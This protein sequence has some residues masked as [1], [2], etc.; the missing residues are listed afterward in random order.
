MSEEKVLD[1]SVI[2]RKAELRFNEDG[3]H[4]L[5]FVSD[6]E[7]YAEFSVVIRPPMMVTLKIA[8]NVS[9]QFNRAGESCVRWS[10][11]PVDIRIEGIISMSREDATIHTMKLVSS[12]YGDDR[13]HCGRPK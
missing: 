9:E 8:E 13:D 6:R 11:F 7:P 1:L 12:P 3:T 2:S 10:E 5:V 4:T